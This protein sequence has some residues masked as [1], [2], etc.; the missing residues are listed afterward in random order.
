MCSPCSRRRKTKSLMFVICVYDCYQCNR[1]MAVLSYEQSSYISPPQT[2]TGTSKHMTSHFSITSY[3][4]CCHG[5]TL[6]V[7]PLVVLYSVT[8]MSWLSLSRSSHLRLFQALEMCQGFQNV[9][10]F[11]DLSNCFSFEEKSNLKQLES[12]S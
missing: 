6:K 7:A 12:V 1:N 8:F 10:E 5:D 4:H 9:Y 2:Q 3:C 11:Y